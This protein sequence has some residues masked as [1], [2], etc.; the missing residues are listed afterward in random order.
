MAA[1][2]PNPAI[3]LADQPREML[4]ILHKAAKDVAREEYREL[5]E[6]EEYMEVYVRVTELPIADSLRDIR[7]AVLRTLFCFDMVERLRSKRYILQMSLIKL[8]ANAEALP[9]PL[10]GIHRMSRCEKCL[11]LKQAMTKM[12]SAG[13]SISIS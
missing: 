13:N 10:P 4:Q 5:F 12:Y 7:H 9:L 3:W 2:M 1:V 8:T 6:N 11:F